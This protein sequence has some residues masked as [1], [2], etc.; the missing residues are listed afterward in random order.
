MMSE[1]GCLLQCISTKM[2]GT[3][4]SRTTY[5]PDP[6]HRGS[7]RLFN[8][9][10]S[11]QKMAYAYTTLIETQN[12]TSFTPENLSYKTST[13]YIPYRNRNRF[14]TLKISCWSSIQP[15]KLTEETP[16]ITSGWLIKNLYPFLQMVQP[17]MDFLIPCLANLVELNEICF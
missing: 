9:T 1:D 16:S 5:L 6:K 17:Q 11:S 3:A 8:L 10:L 15:S 2:P 12:M 13:E 7:F 14:L 4:W